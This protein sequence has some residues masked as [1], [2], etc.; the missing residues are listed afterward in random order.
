MTFNEFLKIQREVDWKK[1]AVASILPGYIHFYA[2]KPELGWTIFGV[3]L[4]GFSMMTYAMYDQYKITNALDF[5]VDINTEDGRRTKSN[6][7]LFSAGFLMNMFAY[8]FDWAH[9][10]WVVETERNEV[11]FKYGL[12]E[13]RRKELGLTYNSSSNFMGV[14]VSLKLF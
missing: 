14:S 9:G 1:V 3:R 2:E 6:A 4:A 5:A 11:Y 10:E 8:A 12:D 7:I 13:E